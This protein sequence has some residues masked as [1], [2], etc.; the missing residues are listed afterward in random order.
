MDSIT[1]IAQRTA[2]Y[3]KKLED[4]R[5][6]YTR[7]SRLMGAAWNEYS[8]NNPPLSDAPLSVLEFQTRRKFL[9][10]LDVTYGLRV[11]EPN[12]MGETFSVSDPKKFLILTIKYGS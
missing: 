2:Q 9:V 12:S 3:A 8:K 7:C 6:F 4:G 10:W 11:D 1:A 5:K